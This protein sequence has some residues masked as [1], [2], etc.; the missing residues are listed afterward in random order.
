MVHFRALFAELLG[1]EGVEHGD[2]RAD[3]R[4]DDTRGA[5]RT[6]RTRQEQNVREMR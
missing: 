5:E 2:E 4:T 1:Y 6:E 3:E